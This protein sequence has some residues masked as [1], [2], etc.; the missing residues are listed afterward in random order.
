MSVYKTELGIKKIYIDDNKVY[1]VNSDGELF[2]L[3]NI[4]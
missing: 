1:L 4:K 3:E 2:E